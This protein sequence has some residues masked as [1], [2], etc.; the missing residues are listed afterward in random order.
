VEV[1]TDPGFT[2]GVLD[3]GYVNFQVNPAIPGTAHFDI[4]GGDVAEDF[5]LIASYPVSGVWSA[6]ASFFI[7]GH[8]INQVGGIANMTLNSVRFVTETVI[9]AEASPAPGPVV[10]AGLPGLLGMLGLG[11][12]K[13]RR[14]K[15]TA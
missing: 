11:G 5:S 13:W 4:A 6:N 3:S 1:V 14:S 15:K 2:G 7:N 8:M 12:W 9:P 10:G